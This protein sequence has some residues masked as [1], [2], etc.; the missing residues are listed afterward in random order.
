MS[1]KRK[2][3]LIE[4]REKSKKK[5]S[6]IMSK[7]SFYYNYNIKLKSENESNLIFDLI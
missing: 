5:F 7:R 2:K 3:R 6:K 4:W 1:Q